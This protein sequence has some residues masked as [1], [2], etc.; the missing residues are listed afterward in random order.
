[1]LLSCCLGGR[2]NADEGAKPTPP[3][4]DANP[5]ACRPEELTIPAG[6]H[7]LAGTLY[8]P[9]AGPPAPAAVFVHGAGPAVRDDGYYELARHFARK[10]VAALIYDKRGCGAST[11]DWT[12]AGLNDLADDALACVRLHRSQ[13]VRTPVNSESA[14]RKSPDEKG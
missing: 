6:E 4:G 10:G 5:D 2:L 11:G 1:L 3:V 9:P 13:K 8:L 14:G 7:Q 12:R